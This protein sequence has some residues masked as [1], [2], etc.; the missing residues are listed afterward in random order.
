MQKTMV[1][2]CACFTFMALATVAA[3]G[4]INKPYTFSNGGTADAN[5][6][7]ANFDRVYQQTNV[8]SA[9]IATAVKSLNIRKVTVSQAYN[10][11]NYVGSQVPTAACG[12]GEV[13]TGGTC[14]CTHDSFNSVTTNY[15][16]LWNCMI[17]GNSVV[18][19]CG[20]NAISYSA[21]KF[22]PPITVTAVCASVTSVGSGLAKNTNTE[23]NIGPDTFQAER[24]A[25]VERIKKEQAE[26]FRVLQETKSR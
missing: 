19:M 13:L 5:Q 7:N 21:T 18:G 15:G 26:F 3:A 14:S 16:L 10:A 12:A 17:I 4:S 8:N 9:N 22:G 24:E 23:E 1:V 11:A 6:V 20:T 2:V 25:A